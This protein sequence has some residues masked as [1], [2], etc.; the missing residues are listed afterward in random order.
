MPKQNLELH[1]DF[2]NER[3]SYNKDNTMVRILMPLNDERDAYL[4]L[5]NANSD[6]TLK[7]TKGQFILLN[8]DYVWHGTVNNDSKPRDML[9]MIVEWN[10][11][12]HSL[13]RSKSNVE[14][15]RINL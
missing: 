3:H 12:L 9:N 13:T 2:D 6:I 11:W 14:I 5:A 4:N 10:D 8:T 7:L 15:E 1:H